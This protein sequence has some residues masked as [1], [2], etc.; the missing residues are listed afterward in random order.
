MAN[1]DFFLKSCLWVDSEIPCKQKLL[2]WLADCQ[3]TKEPSYR[4]QTQNSV[5]QLFS[6]RCYPFSKIITHLNLL[7]LLRMNMTNQ[8]A[9]SLLFPCSF[10]EWHNVIYWSYHRS[11]VWCIDDMTKDIACLQKSP[12]GQTALDTKCTLVYDKKPSNL[13]FWYISRKIWFIF[14]KAL[15]FELNSEK[16]KKSWC[17]V[18]KYKMYKLCIQIHTHLPGG[19]SPWYSKGHVKC[20]NKSHCL[21][22]DSKTVST[23]PI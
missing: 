22:L 6:L 23:W 12:Y 3:I 8:I 4:V 7:S 5:G 18:E 13:I 21:H 9:F 20:K 10:L 1:R 2:Q 14:S 16:K 11:V 17:Y 19:K 15:T